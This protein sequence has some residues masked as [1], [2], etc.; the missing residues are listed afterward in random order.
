M[1]VIL[2]ELRLVVEPWNIHN[3]HRQTRCEVEGGKPD[4]M[5]F[6][7]E[8]HGKENYLVNVDIQDVEACKEMYAENCVN[9]K[10]NFEELVR[11]I[12]PAY[13]PPSNEQEA[14]KLYIEITDCLKKR[15]A[16]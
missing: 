13:E 6:T 14:L 7:P 3:I 11:L 15:L 12:K 4:V 9:Y 10:E 8:I 1:P 2:H 16:S 5:F